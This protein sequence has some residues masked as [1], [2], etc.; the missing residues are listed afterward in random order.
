MLLGCCYRQIQQRPKGLQKLSCLLLMCEQ[1]YIKEHMGISVPTKETAQCLASAFPKSLQSVRLDPGALGGY[2]PTEFSYKGKMCPATRN[3]GKKK[4][5]S[6]VS[7]LNMLEML[8]KQ[9][10]RDQM[11]TMR[12]SNCVVLEAASGSSSEKKPRIAG[13]RQACVNIK[14]F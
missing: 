14:Y 4:Y 6:A 3:V 13:G 10:L 2:P 11:N 12:E 7:Y 5:T 1:N 9:R 8:E